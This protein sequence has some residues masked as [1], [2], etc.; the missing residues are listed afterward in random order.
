VSQ[1]CVIPCYLD[2]SYIL[3]N[4]DGCD[5]GV[6]ESG[7]GCMASRLVMPMPDSAIGEGGGIG[8]RVVDECG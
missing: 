8:G 5:G 6:H 2:D 1:R 3:E 7:I 4:I